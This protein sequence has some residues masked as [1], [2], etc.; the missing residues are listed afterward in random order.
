MEKQLNAIKKYKESGM[1]SSETST[2]SSFQANW[3]FGHETLVNNSNSAESKLPQN[4]FA[5][6]LSMP[7]LDKKTNGYEFSLDRQGVAKGLGVVGDDLSEQDN[8]AAVSGTEH[9]FNFRLLAG[10]Q[11]LLRQLAEQAI[12][13]YTAENGG[14]EDMYEAVFTTKQGE[15]SVRVEEKEKTE[16]VKTEDL[17][18]EISAEVNALAKDAGIEL[19]EDL[20]IGL[21]E[22]G[23]LAVIN[24]PEDS[25]KKRTIELFMESLNQNLA[26]TTV[27][28]NQHDY[29]DQNPDWQNR[30]KKIRQYL[31]KLV[32]KQS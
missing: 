31:T 8:Q 12:N 32:G 21:D 6:H 26:K 23:K 22:S 19:T 4:I 1:L 13:E 24:L 11:E 2:Q 14:T 5:Y 9:W 28:K 29:N 7:E 16:S 20:E 10:E 3:T 25:N 17:G 18:K 15:W 27:K 30:L